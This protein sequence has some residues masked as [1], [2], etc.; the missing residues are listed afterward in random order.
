MNYCALNELILTIICIRCYNKHKYWFKDAFN[1]YKDVIE[2]K[3]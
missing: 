3:L 1:I 2:A